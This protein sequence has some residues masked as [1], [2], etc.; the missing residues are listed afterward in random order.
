MDPKEKISMKDIAKLAGVSASTVSRIINNSGQ[1]SE[2]TKKKVFSLMKK[3]NYTPNMVAKSLKMNKSK[4]IGIIITNIQNEFF[5]SF[6]FNA[7][8]QITHNSH[9][10]S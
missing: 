10:L 5:C 2:K 6:F 1:I 4:S 8:T 7:C 3:Y 9:I